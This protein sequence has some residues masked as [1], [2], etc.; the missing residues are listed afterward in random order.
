MARR[1]FLTLLSM[2]AC[3]VAGFDPQTLVG[4]V[5]VIAARADKP[6]ARPGDKVG[7]DVL[8]ADERDVKP[9]PMKIYWLP[10]Q[11]NDPRDDA[12][13][14]CF[15]SLVPKAGPPDAGA[16]NLP[17]F[18]RPGAD[19]T[20]LL[21]QGTHY[22]VTLPPDLIA[23]HPTVPGAEE[24]YGMSI[25]FFFACAGRVRIAEIDPASRNPQVL[26]VVCTDE[27]GAPLSP[28]NWVFSFTR[29]YAFQTQTNANPIIDA[30][31]VDGQPID[32]Q[33]GITVPPC[34]SKTCKKPKIDVVVP[35]QS[36][37]ERPV[38]VSDP[39]AA[40]HELI[41]ATYYFTRGAGSLDVQGRVLWDANKGKVQDTAVELTPSATAGEGTI[42]IVVQDN[43][44]GTSWVPIPVHVR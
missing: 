9:S 14:A 18:L 32:V 16:T 38:S 13:Y 28:D 17:P 7:V 33:A 24:P 11:C 36:W 25:V 4:G 31:L 8:A 29:V 39:D 42:W 12:Y 5:R 1:M 40:R 37:E 2:L 43:R 44:D 21:P 6:Y 19:V 3:N 10:F 30:V 34:D 20:S 27:S 23:S 41:F 15:S 26:P 22:D 35:M